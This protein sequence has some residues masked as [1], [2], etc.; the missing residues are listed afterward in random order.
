MILH[1]Q[2]DNALGPPLFRFAVFIGGTSPF[3]RSP[4]I[5]WDVTEQYGHIDL[6][7]YLYEQAVVSSKADFLPQSDS[8]D[9]DTPDDSCRIFVPTIVQPYTN[10]DRIQ[11]PTAHVYG[12]K[13]PWKN[14]T[15]QLV[16]LCEPEL[17]DI[18]EH[19]DGHEIP[20]QP[21]LGQKISAMIKS[22]AAKSETMA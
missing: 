9:E 8:S 7:R 14:Q 21:D 2:I 3:S 10:I 16:D 19:T 1:H 4:E 6:K 17:R 15:L 11:I 5:G 22:T 12:A 13:D 18:I 20:L